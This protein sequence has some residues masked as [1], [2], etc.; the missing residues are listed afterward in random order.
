MSDGTNSNSRA[1]NEAVDT[2]SASLQLLR[3]KLADGGIAPSN[4]PILPRAADIGGL[5]LSF[6]QEELW[7]IDQIDP[8]GVT[9]NL[10]GPP[11]R[12]EGRLDRDALAQAIDEI[13]RRHEIL[14]TTIASGDGVPV[15][16]VATE[17][18]AFFALIDL[19]STPADRQDAEVKRLSVIETERPFDLQR[20][21]LLRA[22]LLCFDAATH[23]LLL[24]MHHMVFDGVSLGLFIGELASLY[25]A[26]KAGKPSPL[27]PLP[28]QYGDFAL[29]QRRWLKGAVLQRHLSYWRNRLAGAEELRLPMERPRP[30]RQSG[31]TMIESVR[32]T[33][34][35][36]DAFR[37]LGRREGVTP[38]VLLLAAF[39]A[40]VQRYSGQE[41]IV[42]GSPVTTRTRPEVEGAIGFFVNMV[43]LRT[44]FRG[45][46]SFREL[47][48]RV[49][50]VALGALDHAEVPFDMVVRE[51]GAHRHVGRNPLFQVAFVF[52]GSPAVAPQFSGLST[53]TMRFHSEP[54]S[55]PDEHASGVPQAPGMALGSAVSRFD[56]EAYARDEYDHLSLDLIGTEFFGR[57]ALQQFLVSFR[58]LVAQIVADPDRPL[59]EL[60]LL[61]DA[62]HRRVVLDW[63]RTASPYPREA[64]VHELFEARV[65]ASPRAPAVEYGS[66]R[67]NYG[68]LNARANR[69]AQHLRRLGVGPE[70]MVGLLIERSVDLIVAMLGILK[71]GGAYVPLDP[72]Y[73]VER[74]SLMLGDSGV[75]VVVTRRAFEDRLPRGSA[76]FVV[77]DR[78]AAVIDAMPATDL[79]GSA[80]GASLAYVIYTSGS[81]G[82]PKGVQVEHRSIVRLVRD[83]DYLQIGADDRV[84]QV[85]V[86]SFDAATFEVWAPLL[87]GGCIVGIARDIALS[88]QD[89][90]VFLRAS[91]ITAMFLTT[92]LFNQMARQ[93]PA[94]FASLR[95]LL[96][97]GE[98]SDPVAVREVLKS[99]PPERL[100]HVYGPTEVTTFSL[101]HHVQRVE[102]GAM[103]VPIGRPIANTTAYVL[104]ESGEPVPV[105][106][107]GELYL[108]GDGVARGY[109]S[110]PEHTTR[111]FVSDRFGADPRGRLYRTGDWVRYRAD[112]SIDFI[113]RRDNQ[114]K[115][116]GYRIELGEIETALRRAA[117]LRDALVLVR[118]DAPGDKRVVAYVVPRDGEGAAV[119]PDG[120][121][122]ALRA[123]LPEH[124]VPSAFVVLKQLPLNANGKVDRAALPLPGGESGA[125]IEAAAEPR[126]ELERRIAT[127]WC[128]MLQREPVGVRDNFFDLG[129]HS[130]LLV[131]THAR[132]RKEL[133]LD[134]KVV[135]LFTYPTIESLAAYLQRDG[136]A[137]P[138]A[139]QAR[140]RQQRRTD[141]GGAAEPVAIIGMAGR[142]PGAGNIGQFWAN[143][144]AGRESIR[145]FTTD[146]MRAAGVPE[147]LLTNPAHIPARGYLDDADLFDAGFFGYSARE[148]EAIDPQHRL[149]L[150]CASELLD[151][152]GIDPDRCELPIGVYA[153]ASMNSYFAHLQSRGPLPES[154]SGLSRVL[155]SGQDFLTTRISYKLNLR[156]PSLNVQTACSTSLVAVHQACRAL[157][158]HECDMALAGGV[159][160]SVPLMAGH[161]YV[162]EG[163]GSRDGHCRAFDASA[164]GTVGGNG[165][166]L[167]MLKRL[168][169]ALRDG[170]H[171]H[172]VIRGTAVNNDGSAKVGYT[173]PSV[174]G[175]ARAITLAQAAAQ[176][177][178]RDI[179][180]IEAHGTGTHLGDPIEISALTR[181]FGDRPRDGE[182]CWIGA[183]KTNVGHLDA[184]AGVAGLI[185]VALSI[186]HARIVPSLHFESANPQIDFAHSPFAVNTQLRDWQPAG[187]APRRAGISSF[188]LGGTNA[189]AVL[190][191]APP[192]PPG[193]AP[194]RA[195]QLL[196][197]SAR[198]SSALA[199]AGQAL[200]AH[201]RHNPRLELADVAHTLQAG[202]REF[203]HRRVLA[204]RSLADA[205]PLLAAAPSERAPTGLAPA[206]QRRVV[207]LFSGQGSQ[208]PGMAAGLYAAEPVLRDA[209]DACCDRLA[210]PLGLDLRTLMFPADPAAP[211]AAEQLR[212]TRFAQAAL[213]TI[214][215]ATAQWWMAM[216]VQPAAMLGHSIGELVAACLAGVMGLDDALA[217]VAERGRLM[218]EMPPGAMLS[219]PLPEDELRTL[220]TPGLSVAGINGPSL[221]VVAGPPDEVDA[222]EA[223]LNAQGSA[224]RRLHTSHAFH[225]AMMDGAREPFRRC[226]AGVALKPP[227]RP[228]LS[229]LTGD[230]MSAEQ[231]TDPAYWARQLRAPVQY[232]RALERLFT[233]PSHLLLEVGPGTTLSALA[234]SHPQR[235]AALACVASIRHPSDARDDTSVLLEAAGRLWLHGQRPDWAALHAR[236]RR[237]RVVLPATPMER[238]RYWIDTPL[239]AATTAVAGAARRSD[240]PA[241]WL[242]LPSWKRSPVPLPQASSRGQSWLLLCDAHGLG[243]ALAGRL[244]AGGARVVTATEGPV[245]NRG[246]ADHF[247]LNPSESDHPGRLLRE[248][249]AEGQRP[250]AVVHLWGHGQ[251]L[252][253]PLEQGFFSIVH[254][255]QALAA[256]PQPVRLAVV[257]SR[258]LTVLDGEPIDPDR[259]MALAPCKVVTME[260]PHIQARVLDVAPLAD[261]DAQ[262]RGLAADLCA[263]WTEPVVAWRG[264]QRWVQSFEPVATES[265]AA[266]S[267]ALRDGAAY[268]ITGGLGGVGLEI[269]THLA[270]R[271]RVGLVLVGRTGLPPREG[272][273]AWV[274]NHPADDPVAARIRRVE[275]IEALGAAVLVCRADVADEVQMTAALAIAQ[276]RFGPLAGVVHA[277]GA[278]KR[279]ETLLE[280]T[281]AHCEAQ[282]R[283]KREGLRTLARVLAGRPLDFV[284]LHSSLA[285]VMGVAGFVSYTASHLAMDAFALAQQNAGERMW[286]TVGWDNWALG[287]PQDPGATPAAGFF[288]VPVSA[289]EAL[290]RVLSL[291]DE[292]QVLVSS[293][294]LQARIDRWLVRDQVTADASPTEGAAAA[295]PQGHPR[296]ALSTE[297]T[298]PA[299]V[300]QRTLA[301][302]W[303]VVLGIDR[304]GIHDNFFELGG[305]SVLNIQITGKAR[306]A[307][308]ALTPKQVFE[309]QTIAEL[310]AQVAGVV[311]VEEAGAMPGPLPL[312]PIQA[313]LLARGLARPQHFNLPLLLEVRRPVDLALLQRCLGQLAQRHEALR[314]RWQRQG[315]DWQQWLLADVPAPT[316]AEHDLSA[317]DADEQDRRIDALGAGLQASLDL[318]LGPT[319]ALAWFNLGAAR[320][321]RLLFVIHHLAVDMIGWR[322]LLEDLQALVEGAE[323]GAAAQL[324]PRTVSLRRWAESL[325]TEA[326]GAAQRELP[327]WLGLGEGDIGEPLPLDHPDGDDSVASGAQWVETLDAGATRA[328]LTDL[329][330]LHGSQ[331]NDALLLALATALCG[332][333]GGRQLL[334]DLEGHG[335]DAV[336][337]GIDTSRTV[338]W[339]TTLYPVRLALPL[340]SATSGERL[341]AMRAQ[342]QAVPRDGMGYGLLRYL[343]PQAEIREALAALPAPEVSFLYLGQFDQAFAAQALFAPAFEPCGPFHDPQGPRAHLLE[344]NC[345]V[346]QGELRVAWSYSRARHDEATVAALAR[347]HMSALRALL[348]PST[349]VARPA[350]YS[351][352]GLSARDLAEIARQVGVQ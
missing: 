282:W 144:R 20:G 102:E 300:A 252:G 273:A 150:E 312:T 132:L 311:G 207:F 26:L 95:C 97:G 24:T 331:V 283:P 200:A 3:R 45:K 176:I 163:I 196:C 129:G 301:A 186:E 111:Q 168:S 160:V 197:L 302:I 223:R 171:V 62:G 5:P 23:V 90:A 118:E 210:A 327:L 324:P 256:S 19:S 130:L 84:A 264:R 211:E 164:N 261:L 73:P 183:L 75:P 88:T 70:V 344:V 28:V 115:V 135:D 295:G 195:W 50:E 41:D 263:A 265:P 17:P 226:I 47:L 101:W 339:F 348:A 182:P 177:G 158:D 103:T 351:G 255:I 178:P 201:L 244:R 203:A 225:S 291:P 215:Y 116:R 134:C 133:G 146:E 219:V 59:A 294:P 44:D 181:V 162:E 1:E 51:L 236:Q 189:H 242:Y 346:T 48:R 30:P 124:L 53:R 82:T 272:W 165:V 107:E 345:L 222:L 187:G 322:I 350:A 155:A 6:A 172:A 254:L 35:L 267:P 333:A 318:G 303:Q 119:Q 96:F 7:V 235:P 143:L 117:P 281:R 46:P 188:G 57:E 138:M 141:A 63:N 320:A 147:D 321:P 61:A 33:R 89:F 34:E 36:S 253:A 52:E 269:A 185:K 248:L 142:F 180:Y 290:E 137:D 304:V 153:G 4:L 194:A 218:G 91:G 79:P 58:N 317:L 87:N 288:M 15:Q 159:A 18:A 234:R 16:R 49:R 122:S 274:A 74:L 105:G 259:A 299:T 260:H 78:D 332:W 110:R 190:E 237:L 285:S 14:R 8:G 77:I 278:E 249:A 271:A 296:P 315:A 68:E 330:R 80:S 262:A 148:A 221:C 149:L 202:R 340:A 338:G 71:A 245:F 289:C 205:V 123:H 275:A 113:G 228:L 246:G 64:A 39:A 54:E 270:R 326:V 98:A 56:L 66:E 293:G 100:L 85:S 214:G 152:A 86:V 25:S 104:D 314:L 212:Q 316:V 329:P 243:E 140:Q 40:L 310:A 250:A 167:V 277:A 287:G 29:S 121:R 170:D 120:L 81:T 323:S 128:E 99:R 69:L 239:S 238:R 27:A 309:H 157:A 204:V 42:I 31:R 179:Q 335:R 224:P 241:D 328:L 92:A 112:G 184:A 199:Q 247:E 308:L 106:V 154:L 67:L 37:N 9:F 268:L 161:I 276:A 174:E 21:P 334:V 139:D 266:R 279:G 342:R 349:A 325:R 337:A 192:V 208:Y 286:R 10:A 156:G 151:H 231:A 109:L 169:D 251:T 343:A 22:N 131:R 76:R 127:V 55:Q 11:I 83:T 284:L 280:L 136:T 233:D 125:G 297:Y 341:A 306:I 220:L 217:V 43:V 94:A 313:W 213:F 12:F 32:L 298:P 209:V 126:S 108:G 166:A 258:A 13:V 227:S 352:S 2:G 257:T 38:Y 292:P 198:S 230:W 72:E 191:Q 206:G 173:A 307:G 65:R 114:V 240:D 145:F 175:Q 347:A 319:W 305:D 193:D 336:Q 60:P 216:G 232:A 229:N 93:D